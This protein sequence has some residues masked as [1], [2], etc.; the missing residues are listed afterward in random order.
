MN[1]FTIGIDI[2]TTGTKTVLLDTGSGIAAQAHL[3][4]E[5]HSDGP[6]YAEV[7]PRT[8][9]SNTIVGIREVLATAGISG[10]QVTAISASGMVPAI[11]AVDKDGAPL[12]RAILQNDARA[13]KE[14]EELQNVLA[15]LDIAALSGSAIT[16]QSVGPTVRWLRR[17][18]PDLVERIAYT[19]GSY[20]WLLMALGAS[21]HV[22]ENWALESGLFT[23]SG[24]PITEVFAACDWNPSRIPHVLKPGSAAGGLSSHLARETGLNPGTPLIVGGADHVLSAFAADVKAPGDALVKLGG[25]GDILVASAEPVIDTRLYLDKHPSPG[26][27]LPN[28]CMATSGSLVRWTQSLIGKSSLTELDAAAAGR[29]PGNVLCLPYFLGEKSPLHDV[30]LRGAFAG[31]HLGHDSVDLYRSVLESVAYG[32]RHHREVFNSVGVTLDRVMITNGGSKSALWKQIN[33]DVLNMQLHPLIGHPGASLGAA[34]IAAIGA[35]HL[36]SWDAVTAFVEFDDPITPSPTAVARYDEA[37]AEWR[38]LGEAITPISHRM[39]DR[40]SLSD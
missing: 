3:P 31:L 30:R 9:L 6:G 37:Y 32:F 21:P 28:G 34:A 11:V 14:I 12:R 22:E 2:G 23:I 40:Q 25:A 29:A 16:Q 13:T 33:A 35:G 39:A 24:E 19:V 4:V 20:D 38:S 5:L 26:K 15:D 17:N 18:E 36:A 10:S 7:D 27:W 8:W 1:A